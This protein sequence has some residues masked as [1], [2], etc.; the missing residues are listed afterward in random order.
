MTNRIGVARQ[1][2]TES[3]IERAL[4]ITATSNARVGSHDD[5]QCI[6]VH[7]LGLA[8]VMCGCSNARIHTRFDEHVELWPS[9]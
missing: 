2:D 6:Q 7:R 4:G 3:K 5:V 9:M 8:T 1:R